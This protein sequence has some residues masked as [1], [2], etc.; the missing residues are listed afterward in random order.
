MTPELLTTLAAALAAAA[1]LVAVTLSK[2][3][4][5]SEFRQAWIDGLRDDLTSF[6]SSARAFARVMEARSVHGVETT[7]PA[8]RLFQP[9]KV[10]EIR[11]AAAES[12]YRIK[13]RLNP[14]EQEHKELLRLLIQAIAEQND[15]LQN[16]EAGEKDVLAAVERAADYAQPILKAEW[17]RVKRGETAFRHARVGAIVI[18][19]VSI[20][21]VVFFWFQK[22]DFKSAAAATLRSRGV[23]HQ[24][25]RGIS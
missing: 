22:T 15:A 5:V 11:L 14:D 9:E 1:S 18:I 4:K 24:G 21:L 8:K 23:N 3:Q 2:E 20:L 19:V 13:L 17:N 12:F 10:G 6:L 16:D 7:D 25:Q